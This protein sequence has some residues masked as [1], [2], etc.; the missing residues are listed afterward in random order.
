LKEETQARRLPP[1]HD[2]VPGAAFPLSAVARDAN[3]DERIQRPHR[4]RHVRVP[5]PPRRAVVRDDEAL[6]YSITE[7]TTPTVVLRSTRFASGGGV[8][9]QSGYSIEPPTSRTT[10]CLHRPAVDHH[11]VPVGDEVRGH[12]GVRVPLVQVLGDVLH[13][14]VTL[15]WCWRYSRRRQSGG[16]LSELRK[17]VLVRVEIPPHTT[18][19][20]IP[21]RVLLHCKHLANGHA[22]S[23]RTPGRVDSSSCRFSGST[24]WR[25]RGQG[26]D[27]RGACKPLRSGVSKS[28]CLRLRDA[29]DDGP[30]L[31]A[32]LEPKKL[33][34]MSFRMR[35]VVA[36]SMRPALPW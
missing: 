14:S 30:A 22:T 33:R 2:G 5:V 26:R 3:E 18:G 32:T 25:R 8:S 11:R 35:L 7:A 20:T 1:L 16:D 24:L 4:V 10:R 29:G 9:L 6:S 21:L 19:L 17:L 15:G 34:M 27:G 31:A 13:L 28:T 23:L 36:Q 12:R